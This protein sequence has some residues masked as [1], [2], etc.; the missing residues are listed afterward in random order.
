[1]RKF[2]LFLILIINLLNLTL[3]ATHCP[4]GS[5]SPTGSDTDDAGSGCIRCV[6]SS[7]PSP[8]TAGT[9]ISVCTIH[10]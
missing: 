5:F 3:S 9:D 2:L 6:E 1:M 8:G 4:K 7:T 10:T